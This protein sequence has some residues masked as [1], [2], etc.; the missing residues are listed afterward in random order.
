MMVEP[1]AQPS[2]ELPSAPWPCEA[3][4]VPGWKRTMDVVI[5]AAVLVAAAPLLLA[6][7]VLTR[8]F[9]GPGVIFRQARGGHGGS[10]FELLKLRTM[11]HARDGD[12]R[13][14]P[15]RE[16]THWW[17]NVLRRTSLDELPGLI[18][19]LRG[20][21]SIVG[22]RPLIAIYLDRYSFEQAQRHRVRPGL[23]GLVQTT[24]RNLLSWE[25]RFRLDNYYVENQSLGL[26]V[27]IL[28]DTVRS[29][30]SGHGADGTDHTSE[31][32]GPAD[33]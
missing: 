31:Y 15:D 9:L 22:P 3:Y 4:R 2:R 20:D 11:T 29:V 21:M 23:T 24:G 14:L 8:L 32:M 5:A 13:L 27:R 10:T 6:L 19:V 30:L 28:A 18:N 16:R 17:G 7:M 33:Q 25:E 12:G 26:D 1:T